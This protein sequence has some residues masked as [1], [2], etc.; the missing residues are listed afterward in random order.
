MRTEKH[1]IPVSLQDFAK[2]CAVAGLRVVELPGFVWR[3]TS[4]F[5]HQPIFVNCFGVEQPL[6]KI[7][8][9]PP[10]N[11]LVNGRYVETGNWRQIAGG[12]AEVVL[13]AI[14]DHKQHKPTKG[15][16]YK[17]IP[18]KMLPLPMPK[19][20]IAPEYVGM[21]RHIYRKHDRQPAG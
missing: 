18:Q 17:P 8:N 7:G 5:N 20:V 11:R 2:S 14:G 6:L 4:S 10:E 16:K 12:V 9:G 19:Y 21:K 3:V 15:R 1:G 13:L